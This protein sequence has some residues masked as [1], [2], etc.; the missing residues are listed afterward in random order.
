MLIF[1]SF[2][3]GSRQLVLAGFT[4]KHVYTNDEVVVETL[5]TGK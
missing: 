3:G 5:D 4:P 1:G 2:Q